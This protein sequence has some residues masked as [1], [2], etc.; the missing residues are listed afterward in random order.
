VTRP[1]RRHLPMAARADV[2]LQDDDGGVVG[3][4]RSTAEKSLVIVN[5]THS[6]SHRLVVQLNLLTL[7]NNSHCK[8]FGCIGHDMETQ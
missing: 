3:D 8:E 1:N 7:P 5:G 2:G 4:K 6:Q